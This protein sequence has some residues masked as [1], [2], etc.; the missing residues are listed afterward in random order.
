MSTSA[1]AR[2][3]PPDNSEPNMV[4]TSDT[5]IVNEYRGLLLY[6]TYGYTLSLAGRNSSLLL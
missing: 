5:H 6:A 2:L 1:D 3:V 4:P